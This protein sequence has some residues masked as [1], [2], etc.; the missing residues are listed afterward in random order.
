MM[1]GQ[2]EKATAAPRY[3][4]LRAI[5][6]GDYW[7]PTQWEVMLSLLDAAIVPTV[8]EP[9]LKDK[10]AQ[11]KIPSAEFDEIYAQLKDTTIDPPDKELF[12]A[13]LAEPLAHRPEFVNT[14]RIICSNFPPGA[15]KQ[16]GSALSTLS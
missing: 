16:F 11:K 12:K 5:P 15:K 8:A 14:V 13:F 3:P 4:A 7:N 9:D 2:D 10:E 1:A 6:P